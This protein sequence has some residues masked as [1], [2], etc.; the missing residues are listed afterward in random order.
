MMLVITEDMWIAAV[1]V[2]ITAVVL[3]RVMEEVA[4][5]PEKEK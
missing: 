5:E 2:G 3:A 1:A 4:V